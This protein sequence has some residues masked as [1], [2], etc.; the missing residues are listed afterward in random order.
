MD[1]TWGCL[2]VHF[3]LDNSKFKACN[4]QPRM[5]AYDEAKKQGIQNPAS[6]V[7]KMQLPGFFRCCVYKWKKLR[8]TQKWGLICAA[9]PK[10]AKNY[11]EVPDLVR[12]FFGANTKFSKRASKADPNCSS[13]LPSDFLDLVAAAVVARLMYI[14]LLFVTQTCM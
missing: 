9:S 3:T 10:M 13:I 8:Q 12:T 2:L 11:K 14:Q 6:H 4:G 5:K 7:E 1:T